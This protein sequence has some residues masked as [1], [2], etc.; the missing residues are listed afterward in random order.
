MDHIC[1]IA[2]NI[3]SPMGLTTAEN[4]KKAL[5]GESCIMPNQSGFSDEIFYTSLLASAIIDRHFSAIGD[6]LKYTRLEK[7]S[8]LSVANAIGECELDAKD[9]DVLL[10]Y[11]TTKGN[12]D[13]LG[14]GGMLD[15][16]DERVYLP[17]VAK[18]VQAFFGFRHSPVLVSNACISGLEGMIIA[19]R[20]L[21]SH[22]F[23]KVVVCGGDIVSDFTL[24]GFRCLNALSNMPCLPFNIHRKGIN[25]GDAAATVVL[26]RFAS[27]PAGS[28]EMLSGS[29]TNDA[30]HI[31]APARSGDGLFNA[32]SRV[33][34]GYAASDIDF[35]CAHGTATI[36]NDEMEVTVLNKL[37]FNHIPT[38]SLKGYFGHSL[39][40]AGLVESL[41]AM[42]CL[43]QGWLLASKG[44]PGA[45]EAM[46]VN[47]I[48]TTERKPLHRFLKTSSGFGGCNAAA[49]FELVEN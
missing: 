32:I 48:T 38:H 25:L 45:D 35:I 24:S 47:I 11:C 43:K 39:G 46:P 5:A 1:A 18:A 10:V 15:D 29:V 17:A 28:I 31:S 36:Y 14:T 23:S 37:S 3:T 12:I 8:I 16:T 19:S 13:L 30:Y 27:P 7:M 4:F 21:K 33:T 6:P 49:V 26:S 40:A 42:E 44:V 20:F 34:Q 22:Q 9:E 2:G 41:M